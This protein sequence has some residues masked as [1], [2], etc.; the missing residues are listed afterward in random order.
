MNKQIYT[1]TY[2]HTWK[3]RQTHAAENGKTE[4]VPIRGKHA[5]QNKI[6]APGARRV[7]MRRSLNAHSKKY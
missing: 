4:S 7:K 3:P 1:H 5:E 6:D 2:T